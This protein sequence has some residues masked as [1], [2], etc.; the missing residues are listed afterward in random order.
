[1][2]LQKCDFLFF[3]SDVKVQLYDK[4]F[5]KILDSKPLLYYPKVGDILEIS[6]EEFLLL[7]NRDASFFE[8]SYPIKENQIIRIK[9]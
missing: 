2:F 3:C 1:M 6:D 4:E 9:K 5:D 7:H 8:S